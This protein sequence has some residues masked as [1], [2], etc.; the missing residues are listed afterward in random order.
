MSGIDFDPT[1]DDAS[2]P[3]HPRADVL[4]DIPWGGLALGG[5]ALIAFSLVAFIKITD[6]GAA[7]PRVTYDLA[8]ARRISVPDLP[9]SARNED[10]TAATL[11]RTMRTRAPLLEPGEGM[12]VVPRG[13]I[14]VSREPAIGLA[15]AP[16]A[17]LIEPGL[18]G[19]LPRIGHDGARPADVYARPQAVAAVPGVARIAIVVTGLGLDAGLTAR[20]IATLPGAVTLAF[21]SYG[22]VSADQAERSRAAGHE[23]LLQVPMEGTGDS[24]MVPHMLEAHAPRHRTLDALHWHMSQFPGYIG[25]TPA[26]G[27]RFMAAPQALAPVLQ[28]V[29]FRG[30]V[31]LDA[32]AAPGGL[33]LTLAGAGGAQA[34]RADVVLDTVP[35][36]EAIEAA[37]WTLQD[38]AR[39][40]GSAIGVAGVDGVSVDR[41][42]RFTQGLSSRGIVLVPDS[43]LIETRARVSAR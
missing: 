6:E 16:D 27:A 12:Q 38:L 24:Q 22:A 25:L 41:I 28:D 10:A 31:F 39:E 13:A 2:G 5:M 20:A 33:T 34:A 35:Q 15:F 14:G 43:A 21:L 32:S 42:A 19:L 30:L 7:S 23:V 29:A 18:H 1:L 37:L 4:R 40:R 36:A 3:E 26:Q 17:R 8:V 11:A 9:P